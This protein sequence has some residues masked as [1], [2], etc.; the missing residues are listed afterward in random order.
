MLGSD[1]VTLALISASAL[2]AFAVGTLSAFLA[3]AFAF[4]LGCG[5]VVSLTL[6]LA[7][8]LGAVGI[9][10][11]L[12]LVTLALTDVR[13]GSIIIV[14]IAVVL[15]LAYSI[16]HTLQYITGHKRRDHHHH[17]KRQSNNSVAIFHFVSPFGDLVQINNKKP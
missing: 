16:D 7:D 17:S 8:I 3:Y 11:L 10:T 1:L 5:I 12:A 15:G 4:M 6:A 9:L 2:S 13:L 14:L